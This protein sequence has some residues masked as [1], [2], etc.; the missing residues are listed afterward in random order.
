MQR[1]APSCG[2]REQIELVCLS[3]GESVP[4]YTEQRERLKCFS[5]FYFGYRGHLAPFSNNSDRF[6]VGSFTPALPFTST[7]TIG[8]SVMR[9]CGRNVLFTEESYND[10]VLY[11]SAVL[12]V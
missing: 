3:R 6:H 10:I 8:T 12:P 4:P 9:Q 1:W 7:I 11:L 2:L 5:T